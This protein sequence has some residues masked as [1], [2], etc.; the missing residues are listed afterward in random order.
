MDQSYDEQKDLIYLAVQGINR[1]FDLQVSAPFPSMRHGPSDRALQGP[2]PR[3]DFCRMFAHE[4]LLEPLSEA[5]VRVNEDEDELAVNARRRISHILLLFSQAD[6]SVKTSVLTRPIALRLVKA[7]GSLEGDA[8]GLLLKAVKNLSSAP[9]GLTCLQH[10]G[11]IE[12]LT[13]ILRKHA[14]LTSARSNVRQ[15]FPQVQEGQAEPV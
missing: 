3:N 10:A 9:S 7:L 14:H 1:V 6:L 13:G 5:L 11:A 4:G 12:A 8:L 2:T 15:C